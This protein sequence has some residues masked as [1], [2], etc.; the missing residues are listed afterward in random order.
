MLVVAELS[1][2]NTVG[3]SLPDG[4]WATGL[5]LLTVACIAGLRLDIIGTKT[6]GLTQLLF[7]GA[8]LT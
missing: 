1:G 8:M 5:Q 2:F 6:L 7:G 3:N 4:R